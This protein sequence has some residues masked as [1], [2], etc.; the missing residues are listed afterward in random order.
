MDTVPVRVAVRGAGVIT[1]DTEKL[2]KFRL[3]F[4]V[5]EE[6]GPLMDNRIGLMVIV[7]AVPTSGLLYAPL[8]ERGEALKPLFMPVKAKFSDGRLTEDVPS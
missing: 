3:K 8:I 5:I 2:G 7:L 6:F 1:P 4:P